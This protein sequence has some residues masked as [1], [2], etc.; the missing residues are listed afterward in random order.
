LDHSSNTRFIRNPATAPIETPHVAPPARKV[1]LTDPASYRPVT[2][3][4]ADR[5]RSPPGGLSGDRDRGAVRTPPPPS[6]WPS[7]HYL[8]LFPGDRPRAVGAATGWWGSR[9][10]TERSARGCRGGRCFLGVREAVRRSEA[11]SATLRG[12]AAAEVDLGAP[13]PPFFSVFAPESAP[14]R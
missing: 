12:R 6:I 1:A 2:G 10:A 7:S 3:A 14:N 4:A 9:T 13:A 8:P 11:P 5:A